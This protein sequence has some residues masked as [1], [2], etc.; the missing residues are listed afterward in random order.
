MWIF[1]TFVCFYINNDMDFLDYQFNTVG[2][3][4]AIILGIIILFQILYYFIVYGRVAF[5]K[6]NN[7]TT[8]EKQKY[9]PSVSV[10]MCVKDDAYNLEK[11]LPII[12]EQE[13]PNFEVVVVNDASKDETEYVL[14]V[15]QEIYPNLNVVNLYNN[16]NGF[17][18][19][20][21]PLS[22]GIKSAKNEI[23]LL[24]ESDTMPLNYNWI[25]TMVKGF[26]QKKDI[27]L[28]FTNFEQKPTFLNTLM[29]YEN[30]TSA[31]NYLG[32]AMLNNPYMGQ[33]RN[34]A[35]KREFFF[36]TGG[37][38]SQYNISVGEDDLF[39]NKNA[40]SKNTAV[41]LNRDSINLASPKEKREEWVIQKKKHFK[42]MSH[43][44]LKDKI[45]STLM[46]FA[47]LLIYVSVALSI[48]F[49]FPWQYAILPLV[50]KYTFQIIVY[51]K[52][53]KTLATKQVAFL[54]P[55]LEVL[56]L[57]INT[58]I[59]FFTLFTKKI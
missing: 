58:T 48:L 11:K 4:F 1:D 18:G 6:D 44:K 43:F 54:S 5:F 32:N 14:R 2:F 19:K 30:L 46:P 50:L 25:T 28:G 16:V 45:I 3:Y 7:L 33:G 53:S 23:I 49:Q 20:K 39:I 31:M 34:M 57:F 55:L 10:V 36:E 21:Y 27:V 29:Q 52:S 26:R 24:T 15:L 59:R 13:Y 42:S 37:F 17:L 38:I 9:I 41:V 47:T 22:L 51:Y 8:D 35:Y 12:L 56:F 40:N